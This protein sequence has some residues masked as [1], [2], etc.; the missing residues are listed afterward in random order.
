MLARELLRAALVLAALVPASLVLAALFVSR[1]S[2]FGA[3]LR[4][5]SLTVQLSIGA[6]VLRCLSALF[7]WLGVLADGSTIGSMLRGLVQLDVVSSPML[8]L[9][10]TLALVVTRYSATYLRAEAGLER[11]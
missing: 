1:R 11:T 6:V 9:V 2:P 3:A 10:C 8:L 4:V 5:T 7:S